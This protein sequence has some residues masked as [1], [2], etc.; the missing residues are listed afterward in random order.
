MPPTVGKR[1]KCAD[2]AEKRLKGAGSEDV[3]DGATQASEVK[4]TLYG[5]HDQSKTL[6]MTMSAPSSDEE[7]CAITCLPIKDSDI[8]DLFEHDEAREELQKALEGASIVKN[9]PE[10]CKATL[11]CNHSFH[12][13]S[14]V[15]HFIRTEMKCPV[16]RAGLEMPIATKSFKNHAWF[17]ALHRR[18]VGMAVKESWEG[19]EFE[20]SSSDEDE[21]WASNEAEL[22]RLQMEIDASFRNIEERM[23]DFR[24]MMRNPP[25]SQAPR[26][27]RSGAS[28][29]NAGG[30]RLPPASGNAGGLNV[31]DEPVAA[32][33]AGPQPVRPTRARTRAS[34]E[35]AGVRSRQRQSRVSR[36]AAAT[37]EHYR[38]R[39]GPASECAQQ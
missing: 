19:F 27:G 9:R 31:A 4:L 8:M 7:E 11:P 37:V 39:A 35:S 5:Q 26:A 21:D 25:M 3:G 34:S 14:L 20:S 33:P 29:S 10:L 15:Y 17:S 24:R 30:Q 36:A 32:V 1:R 22:R 6:V 13:L 23:A 18:S 12:G 28:G 38:A 16:C 2:A